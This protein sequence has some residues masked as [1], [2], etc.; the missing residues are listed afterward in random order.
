MAPAN[1]KIERPVIRDPSAWNNM[2][3][4]YDADECTKFSDVRF[5]S[6]EYICVV[7]LPKKQQIPAQLCQTVLKTLSL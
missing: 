7:D 4:A 3:V 2:G 1:M 5:G 6:G